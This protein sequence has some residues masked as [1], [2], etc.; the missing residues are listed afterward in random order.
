MKKGIIK[1]AILF[2]L[3]NTIAYSQSI[4]LV[5]YKF[6]PCGKEDMVNLEIYQKRIIDKTFIGDTLTLLVTA[7]MNC[8]SGDKAKVS[9]INDTLMLISDYA[10]SIPITNRSGDTIGWQENKICECT[11]CFTMEYKIR[12]IENNNYEVLFNGEPIKLLPNKYL[13]PSFTINENDTLYSHDSLGFIYRYSYYE[14]GRIALIRKERYPYYYWTDYYENGQIKSE[15]E[16]YKDID[17]AIIREYDENGNII[18]F[19]D[20]LKK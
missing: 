12:G 2:F 13:P 16:F 9:Y 10:D 1:I 15:T 14:S 7:I 11:C 8:C 6:L 4:E 19:E 17:N 18:R 5:G 3:T 20:N